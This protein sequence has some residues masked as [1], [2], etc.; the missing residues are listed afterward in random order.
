MPLSTVPAQARGIGDSGG[1][2]T[3][4]KGKYLVINVVMTLVMTKVKVMT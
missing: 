1:T 2:N 4:A 3:K